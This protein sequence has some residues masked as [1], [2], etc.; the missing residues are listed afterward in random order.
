MVFDIHRLEAWSPLAVR[1]QSSFQV[2]LRHELVDLKILEALIISQ[3]DVVFVRC[4]CSLMGNKDRAILIDPHCRLGGKGIH[5]NYCLPLVKSINCCL[6]KVSVKNLGLIK[7]ME[8][9]IQSIISGA[10]WL[11]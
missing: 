8:N 3:S 4:S 5:F 11:L 1:R 9:S 2:D 10:F 7:S 6:T